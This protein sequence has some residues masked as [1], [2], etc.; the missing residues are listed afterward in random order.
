M[1]DYGA[2]APSEL[3]SQKLLE[4]HSSETA[5]PRHLFLGV[6]PLTYGVQIIGAAHLLVA[7]VCI[8]CASSVLPFHA[9]GL[10]VFPLFQVLVAAWMLIG[11]AIIIGA[12]IA[13]VTHHR[14]AIAVYMYYLLFTSLLLLGILIFMVYEDSQCAMIEPGGETERIGVAFPCAM[15]TALCFFAVLGAFGLSS[16]ATFIVSELNEMKN[17]RAEAEHILVR[18]QMRKMGKDLALK[19]QLAPRTIF[20][21]KPYKMEE[22]KGKA[23]MTMN[24]SSRKA[25]GG[26]GSSFFHVPEAGVGSF[27]EAM[28]HPT[29]PQVF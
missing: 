18:Q 20:T 23:S 17:E 27:S 25:G 4:S 24:A 10:E 14:T 12:L 13:T 5:E 29:E 2:L 9:F 28:S 19:E 21:S 22:G 6:Y 16:Y 3:D 1:T 11:I 8:S 7:V 15:L 26:F